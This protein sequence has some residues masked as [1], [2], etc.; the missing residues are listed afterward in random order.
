MLRSRYCLAAL[1]LL[2]AALSACSS[3]SSET[4]STASLGASVVA[5]ASQQALGSSRPVCT[6]DGPCEIGFTGPGGGLVFYDAGEQQSWGRFLELAPDGWSGEAEDPKAMWCAE[7][8]GPLGT[9]LLI[10][11]GLPNT[12]LLAS[13]CGTSSAAGV[14]AAYRGGGFDDW[15]LPSLAVLK[16]LC[17][18]VGFESQSG[19]KLVNFSSFVYLSSTEGSQDGT[20]NPGPVACW[21]GDPPDSWP[22]KD[23]ETYTAASY[24]PGRVRPVRAF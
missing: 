19:E 17:P 18:M 8:P 14:A 15:H 6:P 7:D 9:G 11:D 4:E 21:F 2:G 20:G 3:P 13:V 16:A 10:E 24:D 5:S 23:G 1:C 12:K 22:Y